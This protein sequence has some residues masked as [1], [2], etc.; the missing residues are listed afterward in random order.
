MAAALVVVAAQAA[1]AALA[2][3]PGAIGTADA[4]R[5]RTI[6]QRNACTGCH[7]LDRR[8]V[9]PAFRDV[10]AKYRGNPQAPRM[11]AA[12]VRQGGAG[13]WGQLPMPSHPRMS[14]ADIRTV[15]AWIL[16]GAPEQ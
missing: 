14:D 8:V 1:A 11:L 9:G 10:A 4:A 15:V 16:A 7:A 2:P 13:V 5:A 12:K 3:A 6:A